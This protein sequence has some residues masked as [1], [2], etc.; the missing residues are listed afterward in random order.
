VVSERPLVFPPFRLDPSDERLWR[1]AQVLPLTP[2]A[3]A[4]LQYLVRHRG[5]L[6]TKDELLDAVWA[7]VH[8]DGAV[9]KSCVREIRRAIEDPAQAPKFIETV[10]RRGYRFIAELTGAETATAPSPAWE[11]T[12]T[13]TRRLPLVGRDR[14]LARL[15]V[16]LRRAL[17][18]ERQ[19]VVITGE[20]GIGKTTLVE[21]FL[22]ATPGDPK[23]WIAWGQ[24]VEQAGTG[25]PYLPVLDAMG[26]LCRGP[27][28]EL[29][30]PL[31]RRYAPTWLAQL[32]P[33]VEPADRDA[34]QREIFGATP[35]RMLREMV[36]GTDALTAKVALV[37]VL[38]DLH[39]SDHG[40]VDLLTSLAR[41][42]GLAR[43]LILGTF[44]DTDTT[45]QP[46]YLRNAL[47]ELHMHR[48]CEE[49]RLELLVE[50]EVN[51]YLAA[52]F[53]DHRFP[54]ALTHL[55][56]ERTDGN[57]LFM[58]DVV[59]DLVR[60]GSIAQVGSGWELRT[61]IEE[62][63]PGV[64][65]NLR[66][67]ID[68][69]IERLT[70]DEQRLLEAA[71]VTGQEFSVREVATALEVVEEQVDAWSDGLARR[72][73]FL[74][75][76]EVEPTSSATVT[77]RYRF[78]HS[79]YR[80][81]IDARLTG[82][83][84]ARLH[85]RIGDHKE[86]VYGDGAAAFA[87]ELALH[88][89]QARDYRRTVHYLT[90]AAENAVH[91]HANHV[92]LG[93][94]S[95]ALE[96]VERGPSEELATKRLALLERLGRVR[97]LMGDM[98]GAAEDFAALAAAAHREGRG[99]DQVNALMYQAGALSWIDR[100]GSLVA[101]EQA[102]ALS[103]DL[104]DRLLHARALGHWAFGRLLA[105]GWRDEDAQ[106]CAEALEAARQA[107]DRASLSLHA[108]RWAYLQCHRSEYP[109][110]CET[111]REALQLALELDD[112]YHY[113]S[114][115]FH[116][117]WALMHRGELGEALGIL[118]DGL[119]MAE[120]NGHRPWA[121]VFRFATA[122]VYEQAFDFEGARALCEQEL[123][124]MQEPLLGQLLGLIV[125]GAARLG[126]QQYGLALQ[127]FT[128]VIHRLEKGHILMDWILRMPLH[129]GLG[130]CRLARG[131]L[132]PA[133][134]EAAQLSELAARPPERTYLA[135][136]RQTLAEIAL[137][138]GSATRAEAELSRALATLE[139]VEAP[140][141]EWRVHETAMKLWLRRKHMARAKRH[142]ARSAA[143]IRRLTDS[144]R[145]WPALQRCLLSEPRAQAILG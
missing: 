35:E 71:S 2:R 74:R 121:R 53:P 136:G 44:R 75:V 1:G 42:R 94:L 55:I 102:I 73:Q 33:L 80:H 64:P 144:L 24:C 16:C 41:R 119:K 4:V 98:K 13:S 40:T 79:L 14:E 91:R 36:E 96:L 77:P 105:H 125:L 45:A 143:T 27:G 103:R 82:A 61:P 10:H 52:R 21:A 49:L 141:A 120:R 124:R 92:A 15:R 65:E 115:Q 9:V 46:H 90:Q 101:A 112:P 89:E 8:V 67:M 12:K 25:E 123:R 68:C 63:R 107:G 111:S 131:E 87:L 88:F 110:A 37:L 30:V 137:A 39:W 83:R 6:V 19:M 133:R 23:L 28:R 104:G 78:I 140:L 70:R 29:L 60:Q 135:L 81:A 130:E 117:G 38:E 20:P 114:C 56:H 142:R 47:S 132:E 62:I 5:R 51:A 106:R 93:Y 122:W 69:Q 97:R 127:D 54:E 145:D 34:L 43:L 50:G 84:R 139:G 113:M 32:P 116:Q 85:Q 76:A 26:R 3:F 86:T 17:E 109:A 126:L 118:T 31:L 128:E 72:H 11:E 22:Q 57:P 129:R 108:G 18:G 66:H 134:R 100:G 59:D 7:G 95:R 48:L 99:H 58:T 138:E